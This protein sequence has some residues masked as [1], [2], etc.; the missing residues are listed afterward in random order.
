MAIIDYPS[1]TWKDLFPWWWS[2]ERHWK[3]D[4]SLIRGCWLYTVP[5]KVYELGIKFDLTWAGFLFDIISRLPDPDRQKGKLITKGNFLNLIFTWC[6]TIPEKFKPALTEIIRKSVNKS[7]NTLAAIYKH[8]KD[9][10]DLN[11]I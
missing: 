6:S 3:V 9:N 8:W 7:D 5:Q 2:R 10:Y 1:P 11:H 4:E